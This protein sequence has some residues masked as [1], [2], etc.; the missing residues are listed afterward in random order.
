MKK[1]IVLLK[2][3]NIIGYWDGYEREIRVR[4]LSLI[5]NENVESEYEQAMFC[6]RT[7]YRGQVIFPI[8]VPFNF[9]PESI[10]DEMKQKSK[11]LYDRLMR[12][13][14]PTKSL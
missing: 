6:L 12:K 4:T 9:T 3:G 13:H 2:E 11:I 8:I 5:D 14:W 1:I 10:S 7:Q